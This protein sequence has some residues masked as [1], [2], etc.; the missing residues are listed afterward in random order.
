MVFDKPIF[1]KISK[2]FTKSEP[3]ASYPYYSYLY[4]NQ[5]PYWIPKNYQK[6]SEEAYA[7]NVIAYRAIN[8]VAQGAASV[9]WLLHKASKNDMHEIKSH[10]LLTLLQQPNPSYA[11]AEF[12]ENLYAYRMISGNAF[13]NIIEDQY[14]KRKELHILR[15]DRVTVVSGKKGVG[16]YYYSTSEEEKRFFPVNSITGKSQILHLRT[17]HP[18]DDWYGLSPLEAAAY[19]IDQHNN[20]AIWNQ[21]LLQNGARPSGA[22]I[23]KANNSGYNGNLTEEQYQHLKEQIEEKY[24]SSANA[25][26]PLLL[27]GG[28][29]WQEM[30]LSPKDMDFI[31]AKNSAARDIALAF[32][33]PPQLLGLPG[34]NKYSN[35]QEA[36]LALWEDTILPLLDHTI[37]ALNHWLGVQFQGLMEEKKSI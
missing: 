5:E 11:G 36:R 30:S 10:S 22:V 8:I 7:R 14:S 28:L 31:E 15:P 18:T 37:D 26:R 3:K 20:A 35:M 34:D 24:M 25:G 23:V 2:L 21:S 1:Q 12:F 29:E 19:S 27:E 16:G 17:F 6:F 4:N 32:G 33:V 13:I 9:P